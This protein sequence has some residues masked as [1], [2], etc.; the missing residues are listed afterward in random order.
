MEQRSMIYGAWARG[1]GQGVA[2]SAATASMAAA[3][4]ADTPAASAAAQAFRI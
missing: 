2:R 4:V 3:A 1:G